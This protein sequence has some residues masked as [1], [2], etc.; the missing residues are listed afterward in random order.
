MQAMLISKVSIAKYTSTHLCKVKF[1]NAAI[2]PD[3]L[4]SENELDTH[5]YLDKLTL[6]KPPRPAK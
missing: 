4:K 5:V 6:C 1:S 3:L 2:K